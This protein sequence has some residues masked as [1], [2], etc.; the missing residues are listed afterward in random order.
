MSMYRAC[1]VAG[2]L[3]AAAFAQENLATWGKA[4][5]IV[6]NTSATGVAIND[7]L[8]NFPLLVRL[9]ST[10]AEVFA[11]AK[12]GGADLRFRHVPG[13]PLAYYIDNWDSAGRKAEIWVSVDVIYPNNA[14]QAIHM[15]WQ[16]ADAPAASNAAA[17]FD[18]AKGFAG[19]WHLGGTACP[20]PNSVPGGPAA[21]CATTVPDS[22]FTGRSRAGVVGTADSLRGGTGAGGGE[23]FDVSPM[24]GFQGGFTLSFWANVTSTTD[25]TWM[26]FFDFGTAEAADNIFMGRMG[27]TTEVRFDVLPTMFSVPDGLVT[28]QWRHYVATVAEADLVNFLE[29]PMRVYVDGNPA[30]GE[31]AGMVTDALRTSSFLGRS[32]WAADAYYTG[33]MDEVHV[34]AVERNASWAKLS[35]ETQK[36]GANL[37]TFGATGT[38]VS[39]ARTAE[40]TARRVAVAPQGRGY[41]FTLPAASASELRVSVL[42]LHGRSVWTGAVPRGATTLAWNGLKANGQPLSHGMYF[43]RMAPVAGVRGAVLESRFAHTR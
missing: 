1:A 12:A 41:L 21:V 23:Y 16:K 13:G 27:A 40:A 8:R 15:Q 4:K 19:A 32:N 24:P 26:R 29:S 39:V 11:E 18:T 5:P 38:P 33:L 31:A 14:T 30:S 10:H 34:S 36:P 6:I 2:V 42:D 28:N 9:D 22:A 3:A 7:T 17:V 43:V 25:R 37:L 20:R 35:Y